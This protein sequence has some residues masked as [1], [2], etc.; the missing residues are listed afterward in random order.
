MWVCAAMLLGAACD[1][2]RHYRTLTFF[3]DGVPKPG[4][5]PPVG[6]APDGSAGFPD[7]EQSDRAVPRIVRYAHPPY[8]EGKCA[9]CHDNTSGQ[10]VA[11]PQEGLCAP[12]HRDVPGAVRYVHGPVAVKDCLTCHHFHGSTYPSILLDEPRGLCLRCHAEA[13]LGTGP[14]HEAASQSDCTDCHHPHGGAD[15]FFLRNQAN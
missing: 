7:A 6:Y 8:R 11:T 4:E 10:L 5:K 9:A 14:H 2:N 13:D 12:C 1:E 3:F 15:Q